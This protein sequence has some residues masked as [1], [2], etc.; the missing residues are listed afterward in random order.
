MPE[1]QAQ[2][3]PTNEPRNRAGQEISVYKHSF[4]ERWLALA[5]EVMGRDDNDPS[6]SPA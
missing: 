4:V 6:P 3:Q 2:H 5:H 1:K